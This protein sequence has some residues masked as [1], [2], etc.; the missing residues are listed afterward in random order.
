MVEKS[1]VEGGEKPHV[2]LKRLL[3]EQILEGEFDEESRLPTEQELVEKYGFSRQNVRRCMQEL[4]VEGVV[5]RIPGRGTFLTP[6]EDRLMHQFGSVEDFMNSSLDTTYELVSPLARAIDLTN[7]GRLRLDN[8]AVMSA[9]FRRLHDGVPFCYTE[10]HLPPDVG[11]LLEDVPALHQIGDSSRETVI[12]MLGARL[13]DTEITSAEQSITVGSL[14]AA[15][16]SA[17]GRDLGTVTLRID[18]IYFDDADRLIELQVSHFLPEYYAYRSKLRRHGP[19]QK[20]GAR[21]TR[22]ST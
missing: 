19:S 22:H 14:P 20:A 3:S 11:V 7:A 17:L 18:L 2:M 9:A 6:R 12:R 8:D 1:R 10:V 4:V 15:G 21:A 5:Y 16:A 13:Q